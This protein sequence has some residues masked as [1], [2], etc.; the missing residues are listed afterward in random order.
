[1]AE[2]ADREVPVLDD[3]LRIWLRGTLRTQPPRKP[4]KTRKT[5][6]R[7]AA[8]RGLLLL[9]GHAG[10][11]R[12]IWSFVVEPMTIFGAEVRNFIGSAR[13]V[14]LRDAGSTHLA[15][16]RDAGWTTATGA[17]SA[18]EGAP[19]M[20]RTH[21]GRGAWL[22]GLTLTRLTSVVKD[23]PRA[24]WD[25]IA[26]N[27]DSAEEKVFE[28][29]EGH[30]RLEG[31]SVL[32][33]LRT[34]TSKI[35]EVEAE[36]THSDGS[37][38][39]VKYCYRESVIWRYVGWPTGKKVWCFGGPSDI[40]EWDY[41]WQPDDTDYWGSGS[42]YV[43]FTI[44]ANGPDASRRVEIDSRTTNGDDDDC[45]HIYCHQIPNVS[46]NVSAI[47]AAD[48]LALSCASGGFLSECSGLRGQ[49]LDDETTGDV[50]RLMEVMRN[51]P[52][53]P[54]RIY[55]RPFATTFPKPDLKPTQELWEAL[56]EAEA[57]ADPKLA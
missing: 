21:S 54:E 20:G 34:V 24:T 5:R 14:A 57:E 7:A 27:C 55:E 11:L 18:G 44:Q 47:W 28:G 13:L 48:C 12:T 26:S 17:L 41:E 6:N 56:A 16:L 3:E 36:W 2:V 19:W 53:V 15:A 51:T 46:A 38:I 50:F 25:S 9:R 35:Q 31:D 49:G 29:I 42:K 37:S 43:K 40:D 10:V 52:V 33:G 45:P 23:G 32:S 30:P 1:M 8:A 22:D 39:H 4:A